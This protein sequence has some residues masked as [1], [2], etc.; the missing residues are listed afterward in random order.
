MYSGT[1]PIV[2]SQGLTDAVLAQQIADALHEAKGRDVTI[3]SNR[4]YFTG[5]IFR[6]LFM[7]NWNVLLPFGHGEIE[8]HSQKGYVRYRLSILPLFVAVALMSA[9]AAIMLYRPDAPQRY[10]KGLGL[11]WAWLF[12]G[13]FLLGIIRFHFF[14]KRAIAPRKQP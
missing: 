3:A 2:R 5:G 8:I 12:G 13:N 6:S 10:H 11:I 7:S 1:V 14:L 9:L 4:V